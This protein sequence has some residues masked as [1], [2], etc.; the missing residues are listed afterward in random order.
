MVRYS[1]TIFLIEK[2][3]AY[4]LNKV[5]IIFYRIGTGIIG[6]IIASL[7]GLF[8]SIDLHINPRDRI[9]WSIIKS[10]RKFKKLQEVW[11]IFGLMFSFNFA[12]YFGLTSGIVS[13]LGFGIIGILIFSLP[14]S[15]IVFLSGFVISSD[16]EANTYPNQGI[17][18]SGLNAVVSILIGTL[19][20]VV[21][22]ILVI[23]ILILEAKT[24]TNYQIIDLLVSRI[25]IGLGWGI[26]LS[27]II[28][29]FFGG[30]AVI[31]HF[32][33]RLILF[34]SGHAP[35]NYAKFLDWASDKLFLQK[36]GGGYIFVHR[37]LMEHFAKMEDNK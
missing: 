23:G 18:K 24:L 20:C 5:E 13:I 26:F 7:L 4:W 15:L 36:I 34:C 33:L 37:S 6:L 21:I 8:M 2:M 9:K 14:F 22:S 28:W 25:I 3:Q 19:S 11:L 31:Q 17:R 35:W 16:I 29:M 27:G 12:L 1:Q 10:K 30:L 32:V